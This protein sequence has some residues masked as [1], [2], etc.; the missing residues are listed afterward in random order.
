M[1]LVTGGAGFIGSNLHAG[2]HR[3]GLETVVVD[4]LRGQDGHGKWRNLAAHPPAR[5]LPPE[6]LDDFLAT[7]PPI[8]LVF[9]LGAISATTAV[10]GDL[11]WAVN[12]EL[13]LRLWRWCAAHRVRFVYASS[14]ATYGDGAL[15]FDDDMAALDQ[16]R[17]LNLYGWTKHAF[18]LQVARM[19]AAGQER[20]PQWAGLKFFNV[21]GPNEYHKDA[22]ISVVKVKYDEVA[23][24]ERPRLFRSDRADIADGAQMRDFI[25]V[26]DVVDVLL[27]LLDTPVVNG[28]FNLGT[29][30]ARSY[31]DLA[32]AVCAA[33][34]AAD[35]VD[36]IDMPQALHG[37]YQSFTQAA[38]GR[39]REAGYAGQF[40][41]LEDGIARYVR[42]YL[43]SPTQYA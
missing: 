29:G 22:M 42:G 39:L 6:A 18:D 41:T 19:L 8:E 23:R 20:P 12:V 38:M 3:R 26:G 37:Q 33:A 17:P 5:L 27:W 9:H 40:T 4:R 15:G 36:Y 16:L 30:V 7:R 21:Y 35:A 28:L 10:D 11:V 31:R 34:G 24:G 2:L 25:W 13:P 14:A 1:I 43:A 32:R